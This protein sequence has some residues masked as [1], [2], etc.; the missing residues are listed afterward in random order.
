MAL[1]SLSSSQTADG[2]DVAKDFK[3]QLLEG[4]WT[5]TLTRYA[6]I[7][8]AFI[9][10]LVVGLMIIPLPTFFLDI[11]LTCNIAISLTL[12][13]IAIY[14][15]SAL[16][17]SAYPSILLVTTLFRLALNVS[18]TRLILLYGDAGEVITSFGNFVVAGNMVVGGI[19]F[20][21]LM[22]INFIVIAKGSERVSEVAARFTL[23]A[24]PGKQMSI[25]ADMR[26]GAIEMDEGRRRRRD[27]ERESQLF[28]AMDG[29]M[30]F[31]KGDSIAG[32]IITVINVI[33]GIIIG[34]TMGGLTASEAAGKYAML[35]IG[36]GLVSAIPS[37][38]I[39][40]SAGIIVTRVSPEV[41]GSNLGSDI[42][43]Q[44]LA[45]HKPY[46][47]ISIL[48]VLLGLVPGL[49][50]IPFFILSALTGFLAYSLKKTREGKSTITGG[51]GDPT[52]EE[53]PAS[54]PAPSPNSPKKKKKDREP[55]ELVP[56]VTPIA[57][58]VSNALTP[59]VDS[60]TESGDR[61]LNEMLPLMKEGLFY[62]LGVIFPGV[63]IRGFCSHLPD[64]TYIIK[65]NE[66]PVAVGQVPLGK[67]LVNE[68]ADRLAIM[69]VGGEPAVNPANGMDACWIPAEK[70]EVVEQSGYTTW[71][72]PG[73]MILHMSS[74]L[75]RFAY[76]FVGIQEIQSSLDKLEQAF[77]AL[78]KEVV[79]KVLSLQQFTDVCRRL[80]EEEISIVNLKA[81]LEA[82]AEWAQVEK[83][84]VMLT[85]YVRMSMK[86]YITYKYSKGG[87]TLVVYLLDPQIEQAIK[88]SI[89]IT[90]SGNYLALEPEIAQDILDAVRVEIGDLPATAQQPVILTN[91][92]IRRYFR[93][94]VKLEFP[95]LAVLSFQEL[96]PDMNIQPV[97][98]I[99]VRR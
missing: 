56:L 36:D 50:K 86:R 16:H 61:F 15:P 68:S 75:R 90:S 79:P 57:L 97:A 7:G 84:P 64:D 66:V 38:L 27:L 76:E 65:L 1:L 52:P 44:L 92:E 24:M 63:R 32:I 4:T 10:V 29:A 55:Q 98:R 17:L 48:L 2:D 45:N 8:L 31:V 41:E 54:T 49:P 14:M 60:A 34:V 99:S 23:D 11:L 6:D 18:S 96:N 77:P 73:Y 94:L 22:L 62:E 28:G 12:V 93:Q 47:I 33:G 42:G 30:K 19:I 70:K 78:I 83:D 80:V 39:S 9:V 89:Q 82:L 59:Y 71:D 46:F 53:L 72:T 21:I 51:E 95:Y 74:V 87:N 67:V 58:E 91:V 35:T 69:N 26:A 13:L 85:E 88:D 20:L 3:S 40:V 25:D 37:L 43:T 81:I 5:S